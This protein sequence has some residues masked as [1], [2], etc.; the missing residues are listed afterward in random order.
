MSNVYWQDITNNKNVYLEAIDKNNYI[1]YNDLFYSTT[2]NDN[3]YK[4]AWKDAKNFKKRK[5]LVY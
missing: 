5:K 4:Q 3:I 2:C 1:F